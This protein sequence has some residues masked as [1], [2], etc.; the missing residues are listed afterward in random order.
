VKQVNMHDAKT[1]LSRYVAELKPGETLVICNR[2]EPVAEI[3]S[4]VR[5][6]SKP[7]V[8]FAKGEFTVPASFFEPLPAEF[9]KS[10]DPE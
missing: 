9:L 5:K 7:R 1:N 4:I 2:N 3:R 6:K 8:D 10:F